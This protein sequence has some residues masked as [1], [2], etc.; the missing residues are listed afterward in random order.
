MGPTAT[1]ETRTKSQTCHVNGAISPEPVADSEGLF[2]KTTHSPILRLVEYRIDS[3]YVGTT[4]KKAAATS[5]FQKEVK[6]QLKLKIQEI[7]K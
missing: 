4:G 5:I 3:Q 2:I 1:T 6:N 7:A